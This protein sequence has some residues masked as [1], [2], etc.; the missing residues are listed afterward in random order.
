[1][2]LI[3]ALSWALG[4]TVLPAALYLGLLAVLARPTR[5]PADAL[6]TV[7]FAVV[8]PA[9]NEQ[10]QIAQTVASLKAMDYPADKYRV[11]VVADNCTDE[12]AAGLR[13]PAPTSCSAPTPPCGARATP[14]STPSSRSSP[15]VR[16]A[17]GD[18]PLPRST[19]SW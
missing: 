9:H 8:V 12:T 3:L 7:R 6:P 14:S 4:L 18:P 16:G 17:R 19:R 11:V 5:P 10:E 1:M 13:P 2:T 15:A